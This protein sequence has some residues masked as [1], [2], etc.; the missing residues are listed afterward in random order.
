MAA[1]ERAR[2]RAVPSDPR[3]RVLF[4]NTRE[5]LGADVAVHLLLARHLDRRE[6]QVWAATSTHEA[7]GASARA[8]LEDI[9]DLRLIPLDLRRPLS[10]QRG[11]RKALATAGNL[12]GVIGLGRLA[13][14]C[15]RAHVQ[16]IHVTER[17]R[18][19]LFGLLLARAAGAACCIHA[20]TSYY[21]HDATRLGNW[22]LHRADAVIGVSR[23]TAGTYTR[24]LGLSADRVFAVHNAVDTDQFHPGTSRQARL[25]V[26]TRFGIPA[27]SPL[28]G[29]VA[30]LS[31]WKG[32]ADLLQAMAATRER[33]P[34]A[35][36][37]IAGA[38]SDSAPDGR[39]DFRA[40]L[41]RRVAELGLM[42]AV[43]FAGFV[44]YDE[45]P[46]FYG[47][48]D[49]L[50]HPAVEE[51]FGLALVEAMACERAVVAV[52]AGGVPEIIRDG[53]D[54]LLVPREA[55]DRLAAALAQVLDDS[56]LRQRLGRAARERVLQAFTPAQQAAA[57]AGVYRQLVA[58]RA[59]MASTS[60]VSGNDAPMP[61]LSGGRSHTR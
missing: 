25:A 15:R 30:R 43:T 52:G 5:S 11:L 16:V 42:D 29:C 61:V 59:H 41:E 6:V 7:P 18:D 21:A 24:D 8:A 60:D 56:A 19:A 23:F 50:A 55:P 31:R 9:A 48:L 17:P 3:V 14:L 53:V 58:Q 32:Q 38:A 27:E 10:G 45:M 44:G 1:D 37:V 46:A 20:H 57:V 26:R 34:H 40:Y 2:A 22:V 36:L 49:V 35:R 54:G 12:R 13:W 4:L 47:A 33:H 51:P 39:G 28:I